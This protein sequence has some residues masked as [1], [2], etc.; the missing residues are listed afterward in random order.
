[1][2]D[3]GGLIVKK[4]GT[5][6]GRMISSIGKTYDRASVYSRETTDRLSK[7]G[8]GSTYTSSP[9]ARSF[10][11]GGDMFFRL[12][13][14]IML[15]ISVIFIFQTTNHISGKGPGNYQN[16]KNPLYVYTYPV[17]SAVV[18]N[19]AETAFLPATYDDRA[20]ADFKPLHYYE[21]CEEN[22]HLLE[23]S[24]SKLY[25]LVRS[26]RRS[27]RTMALGAIISLSI[28]AF[29][30]LLSIGQNMYNADPK[31]TDSNISR[32][33]NMVDQD[34]SKALEIINE[35]DGAL[36]ERVMKADRWFF[37]LGPYML[38]LST[39]VCAFFTS[40]AIVM[41]FITL[42]TRDSCGTTSAHTFNF[43]NSGQ[44]V[45]DVDSWPA[46]ANQATAVASYCNGI[47]DAIA[48]VK[49][50]TGPPATGAA[51]TTYN[52]HFDILKAA[53]TDDNGVPSATKI[54]TYQ[55]VCY[56]TTSFNNA[57]LKDSTE[58]LVN[59]LFKLK[60]KSE[61]III[62]VGVCA[63]FL[64]FYLIA[65]GTILRERE[66]TQR[67]IASLADMSLSV[68]TLAW[69]TVGMGALFMYLAN[70]ADT[71]HNEIANYKY[72]PVTYAPEPTDNGMKDRYD[73]LFN[74]RSDSHDAENFHMAVWWLSV[75]SLFFGLLTSFVFH[76]TAANAHYGDENASTDYGLGLSHRTGANTNGKGAV[77]DFLRFLHS[78]VIVS[79]YMKIVAMFYGVVVSLTVIFVLWPIATR[80]V[81]LCQETI[82]GEAARSA[83]GYTLSVYGVGLLTFL[84]IVWS[85]IGF[86]GLNKI[87]RTMRYLHRPDIYPTVDQRMA[88]RTDDGNSSILQN[89]GFFS[90]I[91]VGGN[92]HNSRV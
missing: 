70:R 31:K 79:Y 88:I 81:L 24:T 19:V 62:L 8:N 65:N 84:T 42:A 4:D 2:S 15:L 38:N 68:L 26:M 86:S 46:P 37:G 32:R 83:M 35:N 76:N 7:L 52:G 25:S 36:R 56:E 40:A 51:T 12:G 73:R 9:M 75:V 20:V 10:W 39:I 55:L 44:D 47:S 53:F 27:P 29:L 48:A 11:I 66:A 80:S 72:C 67:A 89:A 5:L 60:T 22:R 82:E 23:S 33:L 50:T 92:M 54:A 28:H 30:I 69:F 3:G 43:I 16:A 45:P 6:A 90:R 21:D 57:K 41:F 63:S 78:Q 91:R 64:M 74:L 49:T 77:K 34:S 1:M 17:N 58:N 18:A 71:N 14:H 85:H 61:A 87:A 59:G 13:I